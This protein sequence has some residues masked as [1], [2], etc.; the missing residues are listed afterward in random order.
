MTIHHAF[1][2]ALKFILS[3]KGPFEVGS[4]VPIAHGDNAQSDTG[5]TAKMT[6]VFASHV[7]DAHCSYNLCEIFKYT[8][9]SF[10]AA[11]NHI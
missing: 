1:Q 11:C 8:Q 6:N 4:I 3:T 2:F 10:C 9:V 5:L 7:T